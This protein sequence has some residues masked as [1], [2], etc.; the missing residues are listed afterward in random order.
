MP[1]RSKTRKPTR[2]IH[3]C[4]LTLAMVIRDRARCQQ[5]F[6]IRAPGPAPGSAGYFLVG[7]VVVVVG[8]FLGWGGG[9]GEVISVAV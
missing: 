5:F 1:P 9:T 2:K 7:V 3:A 6:R 4:V 8:V